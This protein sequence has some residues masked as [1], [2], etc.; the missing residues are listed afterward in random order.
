MSASPLP[1]AGGRDAAPGTPRSR[2]PSLALDLPAV[3][4]AWWPLTLA[5]RDPAIERRYQV[6]IGRDGRNGYR[7]SC[8][9][10]IV[11]W[12]AAIA[13]VPASRHAGTWLPTAVCLLC[14]AA[15]AGGLAVA[16]WARTLDRQNLAATPIAIGTGISALVL[17]AALD[18]RPAHAAGA[19][20]L[21]AVFWFIARVRFVFA[22]VRMVALLV[23]FA[24]LV[25][26]A[27]EPGTLA[28]DA[29]LLTAA[30][31][32]VLIGL[33][34]MELTSRR[35]FRT[36]MELAD[37]SAALARENRSVGT[38]L[39]NLLPLTVARR[40][41][42]GE[43][44]IADEVPD[45]TVLFADL[46]GFTPL[47]HGMAASEVVAHLDELFSRFDALADDA[48]VEKIKTIGDA[49]MAAGGV[50]DPT[51]HHPATIVELGV[52]MVAAVAAYAAE[53]GLPLALRV[54]VHT[55]PLVAGVIGTRKLQYDL[56]GDTVNVASRLESTGVPGAVQVSRATLERLGGRYAATFRGPV[57]LKGVGAVDTWLVSGPAV[58]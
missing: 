14:A 28:L 56:W 57:L 37:R 19:L 48:G 27:P 29:F 1:V 22:V 32:G 4:A 53:T 17:A 47:A 36:E 6:A 42:A 25:G 30:M 13:V 10:G 16:G 38:L 50:P 44:T 49:W 46:A 43:E 35:L 26:M 15:N 39:G 3:R 23:A 58:T 9:I 2:R 5:F 41:R 52:R 18:V 51:P 45:A 8:L 24:L 31:A 40:L 21:I 20:V 54:G 12:L 55:G 34:R 33:Y 11:L 7:L